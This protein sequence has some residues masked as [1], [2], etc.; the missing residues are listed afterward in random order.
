MPGAFVAKARRTNSLFMA[1]VAAIVLSPTLLMMGNSAVNHDV[2]LKFV[3]SVTNSEQ[4]AALLL[5][6]FGPMQIRRKAQM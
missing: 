1:R 6:R 4:A 3:E 5:P 2:A